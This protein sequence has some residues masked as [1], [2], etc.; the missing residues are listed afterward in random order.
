MFDTREGVFNDDVD[1]CNGALNCVT[2]N[3]V[4]SIV[5]INIA[6]LRKFLRG[7]FN[8][9][10]PT[11]TKYYGDT[12]H[13]LRSTDVPESNGWVL[14]ISDRRGD[15]DFDGEYDME[16]IYGP[17]DNTEQPGEDL[18]GKANDLERD[19][20]TTANPQ[21][22]APLCSEIDDADMSAVVDHSYFRRG[23]R[24]V[25]GETLP[26]NYIANSF[27]TTGFTVASENAIYVQGNYNATGVLSYGT[28]TPADDYLPQDTSSHVP[29]SVIGD[30][31]I[32]LSN[33]WKDSRSF[34]YPFALG[35]RP[36]TETTI[37]FAMISGDAKSSYENTPNQGGGDP[38]LAGGV[39]N[40]KRFLEN[41]GG[42]YLNYS[43]S[44]INLYNARNNNG[45]FKCCNKVYSP[46]NRNWTFDTSFLSPERLPPG[47]PFF[48]VLQL[49]GFQRINN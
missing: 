28:P 39:H 6:N 41:W 33:N 35:S 20:K 30:A 46:P 45:A 5:E 49:T 18:D 15:R 4:M 36:A 12:G 1:P 42:D 44:L 3:G 7:D 13:V 40:F 19:F 24:L 37:R 38:R 21:G 22:E 16:D 27:D 47:T 11:G 2:R 26:G 29:A 17:C 43:G 31:V 48:Q 8:S 9:N 25:Q 32:I 10:M 34:R 23:V 14:Y